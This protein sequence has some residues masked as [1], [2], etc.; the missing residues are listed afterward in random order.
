MH[1]FTIAQHI[2][3]TV[4]KV[5]KENNAS[6]VTEISLELNVLSHLTWEQLKFCLK[7]LSEHTIAEDAHIVVTYKDAVIQ[8]NECGYNGEINISKE[9][10]FEVIARLNCPRCD[11]INT[12]LIGQT[13]CI[14][15]HIRIH[16]S[17]IHT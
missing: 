12:K 15:E 9:D 14:I 13:D 3:S 2:L 7:L 5:A 16:P 11:G 1:E 8:C 17:D 6:R 4:L 10:S